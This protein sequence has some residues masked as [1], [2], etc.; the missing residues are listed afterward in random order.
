MFYVIGIAV[1]L[2]LAAIL[3][4]KKGKTDADKILAVW[5][6][7]IGMHLASFY[8]FITGKYASH[9]YLLG[10]ELPF[11]LLHGPLLYLYTGALTNQSPPRVSKLVHFIP[12]LL[13]YVIFFQFISSSP[14]HKIHVYKNNGI[15]YE[16]LKGVLLA[17][18]IVSGVVYVALS[19]ILLSRHRNVIQNEFSYAERVNLRWLRY[20]IYGIAAIWLVVI[21]GD[22][23]ATYSAV[24]LF[25]MMLGYFGIKQV[26]IFTQQ[27]PVRSP[28]EV[29][30]DFGGPP[31]T[32]SDQ[33]RKYQK[34]SLNPEAAK[35]IHVALSQLMLEKKPYTN[36]DLTLDELAQT[37]NV[38]RNN[39]SQVIN[40]YEQKS[41]Y[42]YI[43]SKR[44]EEFKRIVVIPENQRFSLLGLANNSGFNSK[45][46]FHRNFKN[47]TGLSPM[48]YLNQV[49]VRL[50]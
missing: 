44:I 17:V 20:L 45:T 16:T 47:V 50:E 11:P 5:L 14:E 27:L 40:T 15:G 26:G 13:F 33:K 39:L 34:S 37:L 32:G 31:S 2:F 25:V 42:D 46:S 28:N 30:T 22:D 29:V 24:V 49:N 38:H 12:F 36:P 43:N 8:L 21:V 48:E 7:V 3:I 4:T 23:Q 41:F 6:V 1:T 35:S 9:P 10:L 18:I 19:L